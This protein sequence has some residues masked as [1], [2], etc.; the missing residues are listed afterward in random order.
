MQKCLAIARTPTSTREAAAGGTAMGQVACWAHG[1][2]QADLPD[3]G[4]G[5]CRSL[6]PLAI[7][8]PSQR[9]AGSQELDTSRRAWPRF[10]LDIALPVEWPLEVCTPRIP[11][12]SAAYP[13]KGRAPVVQPGGKTTDVYKPTNMLPQIC[14]KRRP[15]QRVAACVCLSDLAAHDLGIGMPIVQR[16]QDGRSDM[17]NL[18]RPMADQGRFTVR[19]LKQMLRGLEDTDELLV[20]GGLTIYRI[21]RIDDHQHFI[22]FNAFEPLSIVPF[23][24]LV[25]GARVAA[26][27]LIP[28]GT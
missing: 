9:R 19:D 7:Q 6:R 26:V 3:Y 13:A 12:A 18:E 5:C 11:R 20:A 23:Q 4:A 25:K 16:C 2:G 10:P 8:G 24:E 17:P 28:H 22:E 1:C 15:R 27:F 21:K 14:T